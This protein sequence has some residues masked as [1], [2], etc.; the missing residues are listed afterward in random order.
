MGAD[1][2]FLVVRQAELVVQSFKETEQRMEHGAGIVDGFARGQVE[3]DGKAAVG[4]LQAQIGVGNAQRPV[5]VRS[6]VRLAIEVEQSL[7]HGDGLHAHGLVL[8]LGPR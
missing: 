3:F 8:V 1:A 4:T 7:S 5:I 6:V 2:S